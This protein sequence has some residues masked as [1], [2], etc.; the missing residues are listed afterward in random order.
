MSVDIIKNVLQGIV[1]KYPITKVTLFGSRAS[2]T[3]RP[4]SDV[5][6]IIEF[7][8]PVTL[9]MLAQIK[10]DLEDALGL[11]VDVIHGP[12]Q[13]TDLIDVGQVVEL[14]AA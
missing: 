4:D 10:Y 9:M 5:D 8:A 14:Y 11:N 2:Q 3:N 1:S 12:V 6:L 13:E 7:N